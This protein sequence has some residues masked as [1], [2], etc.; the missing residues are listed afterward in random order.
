MNGMF[1]IFDNKK[2]SVAGSVRCLVSL[3]TVIISQLVFKVT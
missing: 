2:E 3:F 1:I